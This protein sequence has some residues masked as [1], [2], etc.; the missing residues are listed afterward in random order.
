M[1]TG[2][3]LADSISGSQERSYKSSPAAQIASQCTG[4]ALQQIH[5]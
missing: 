4:A 3:M 5:A 2:G 1:K